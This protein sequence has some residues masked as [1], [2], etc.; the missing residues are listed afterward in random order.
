MVEVAGAVAAEGPLAPE[1]QA[2]RPIATT[3]AK[4]ILEQG[5]VEAGIPLIT[6]KS[7]VILYI[8]GR[9]VNTFSTNFVATVTTG[10]DRHDRC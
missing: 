5:C 6:V 8:D 9:Q 10:G 4:A 1:P 2:E 7:L 3:P